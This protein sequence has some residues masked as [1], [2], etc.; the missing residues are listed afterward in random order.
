MAAI[1]LVV[2]AT[3]LGLESLFELTIDDSGQV[4]HGAAQDRAEG[5]SLARRLVR[6][7]GGWFET[8]EMIGG[9]RYIITVPRHTIR[10]SS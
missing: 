4:D 6:Q 9:R 7:L 8:P 3:C 2:P 10:Q 5:S 1:N